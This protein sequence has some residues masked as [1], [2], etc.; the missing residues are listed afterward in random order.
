M[1]IKLKK[2]PKQPKASASIATWQRYEQKV[3][4]IK[5]VNDGI[6][7]ERKK[8]SDLIGKIQKLKK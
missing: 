4:D 6:L 8:K 2:Y 1:A 7:S 3:K 5:K